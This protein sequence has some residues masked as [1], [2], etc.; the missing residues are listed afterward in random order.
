MTAAFEN[1]LEVEMVN[2][3]AAAGRGTWRLLKLHAW[4]VQTLI[5]RS[6]TCLVRSSVATSRNG[7]ST[8]RS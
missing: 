6:V 8:S 2:D 7:V 1:E 3:D 5:T 4:L